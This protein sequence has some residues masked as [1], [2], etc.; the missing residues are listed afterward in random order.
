VIDWVLIGGV[1]DLAMAWFHLWMWERMGLRRDLKFAMPLTRLL[2]QFLNWGMAFFLAWFGLICLLY[3]H[4]LLA[5]GLGHALLAGQAIF[6]VGRTVGQLVYFGWRSKTR[7]GWLVLFAFGACTF[8]I[9]AIDALTERWRAASPVS[10]KIGRQ[11]AVA[12]FI[13]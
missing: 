5:T 2:A 3:A 9:P 7:T 13:P 6:W 8:A 12:G 1:Y 10:R 4:D 11:V